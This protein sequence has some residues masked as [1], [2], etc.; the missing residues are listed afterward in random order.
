MEPV[1]AR[2][3][4]MTLGLINAWPELAGDEFAKVTRPE[5]INW[6]RR[7]NDDDPFE[8]AVLVVA[9]E[10]SAALFFQHQQ[11]SIVERVNLF[12]GFEA[13]KRIQIVQ[14]PVGEVEPETEAKVTTLPDEVD[15]KLAAELRKI[16][17]PELR[18]TLARLGRGII[19]AKKPQ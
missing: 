16:E 17:D 19:S 10:S 9:C 5:K 13:V 18:K 8:P 11:N 6:P 7:V 4:G 1:L 14:K 3:T 12:F 15:V 2:R